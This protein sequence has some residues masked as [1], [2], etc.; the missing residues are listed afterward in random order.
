MGTEET[1]WVHIAN[2]LLDKCHV[3]LRVRD[4]TDCGAHVFVALYE[5]ILGE[6]VPD[7][8]SATRS[9]ERDAHNVQSV[10]DSLAL[11]YLQV[12]L[13]HITG[14]NV[15]RGD[16]ESIQ[17]LLEIFDGLLEYLSEQISEA[18]SQ[19]GDFEKYKS[20][21]PGHQ[22]EGSLQ[23][24]N[25]LLPPPRSPRSAGSSDVFV[26]SW[27]ADGSGSTAELIRLGDTAH[28]FTARRSAP[29]GD[30][31]GITR[32]DRP[33]EGRTN[34]MSREIQVPE[35]SDRPPSSLVGRE[36]AI[37]E[38]TQDN[39]GTGWPRVPS[40]RPL[41][42][43]A[44]A[45]TSPSAPKKVAFRTLPEV[46]F[47]A[48]SPEDGEED[49]EPETSLRLTEK[50]CLPG[51]K[52][53]LRDRLRGSVADEPLSVRR[54]RSILSEQELKEMSE[55]LSRR[56]DELDRMLKEALEE[57]GHEEDK[58]SQH[59]D[60]IMEIGRKQQ[61][62]VTGTQRVK[63]PPGRA[64][65]V[66]SPP[67][68][69]L[70]AR[71]EDALHKG[72][73]GETG[74]IRRQLQR[75]LDQQRMKS[76]VLSAA[77]E[78][79]L[80]D[81]QR[82]ET[83]KPSAFKTKLREM[84]REFKENFCKDPPKMSQPG[85]VYS[86]KQTPRP[87]EPDP[88]TPNWPPAQM[89]V[90]DD[91]LLPLVLDAFPQLRVSPHA[92]NRMWRS[93]SAQVELLGNGAQEDERSQRK[94]QREVEEAHK[95]FDLLTSLIKKEQGHNQRLKD[96]RDRIRLQKSAQNKMREKRQQG[97]RAKRYYHDYHVQLRAKMMRA[98]TR[99]ERIVKKLFADGLQLQRQRLQEMRLYAEEQR[100]E[101]RKRHKDELES[102][103]NYYKD[104]F[105]MLADAVAQERH[106]IQAQ[107]K[108]QS[109]TLQQ[110]KRELRGRM[111]RE[112]RDL[113]ETIVRADED[114]FFR[115]LEAERFKRRLQM[116]S[117]Q[118]SKSH[119]L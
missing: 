59:S 116:A 34:Y 43:A 111:E 17:N 41:D 25:G 19:S 72:G 21:H 75:E 22:Q 28:S 97:A 53:S 31:M 9:Q 79:R 74:R 96:F 16:A 87:A 52:S 119:G 30:L 102:M 73:R 51:S 39:D 60:S 115:E 45:L 69:P 108:A 103:E 2:N 81:F 7:Y 32:Q 36:D 63:S 109:K 8:I 14:E 50:L 48:E 113:Q 38:A 65:S 112:I 23:G 106:E 67:G 78:E 94:L 46:R 47:V 107:E 118:Y 110:M 4:L 1:G 98:R 10:I 92:L 27:E 105:S 44:P 5:A 49:T 114:A 20:S 85:R 100:E 83:A 57:R 95:K 77:Y 104:Q 58:L 54:A 117:F 64:R 42:V 35:S 13:S 99:E 29:L 26:P 89:R 15:V 56:L 70:C 55:K 91:D 66:S 68:V 3:A 71:F 76:Q 40:P 62:P 33:V 12:S 101:Q 6:K 24:Q 18:S 93:Q 61:L 90:R 84:E 80:R 82:T 86:R 11:D 37:A 88:R